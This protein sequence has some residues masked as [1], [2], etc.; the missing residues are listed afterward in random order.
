[1]KIT[2]AETRSFIH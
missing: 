2:A 1:V